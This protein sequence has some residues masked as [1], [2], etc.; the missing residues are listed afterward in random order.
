NLFTDTPGLGP[1]QDNGGPTD[2]L[3]V[4]AGS[5]AINT[6]SNTAAAALTTDQRGACCVRVAGATV[7]IGAFEYL[8]DRIFAANFEPGT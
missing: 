7:D 5:P 2:T 1:L 6:G 8:G 3:A 4:L